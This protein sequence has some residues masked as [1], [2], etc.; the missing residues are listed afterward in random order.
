MSVHFSGHLRD[1]LVMSVHFSGHLRVVLVMPVHFCG[2]RTSSLI[3][4]LSTF[5]DTAASTQIFARQEILILFGIMP[6][7]HIILRERGRGARSLSKNSNI[8]EFYN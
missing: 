7:W 2:H 4:V 5:V 1:V 6:F 8:P 3:M